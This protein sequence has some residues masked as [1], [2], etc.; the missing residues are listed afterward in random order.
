M[1]Q[2]Y[3]TPPPPPGAPPA[4]KKGLPV[5]AWVAIGCVGLLIVTGIVITAAGYW[6]VGK[7]KDQVGDFEKN[8][9]MAAAKLIVAANPELELISSDDEAQTL[10]VRNKKSG[11]EVTL[12]LADLR[13]GKI[14]FSQDGKESAIAFGTQGEDAGTMTVTGEGGETTFRAGAG[15]AV[16]LPSWVPVYPGSDP[17]GTYSTT[18]GGQTTGA[19]SL[20]TSDSVKEVLDFYAGELEPMG[21]KLERSTYSAGGN[22]GGILSG[23]TTDGTRKVN[24][25]VNRSGAE[26]GVNLTYTEKE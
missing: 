4:K 15:S 1:N 25:V 22:E 16:E 13:Q 21:A 24:L 12:S 26:T 11:E 2:P 8:P 10:T 9:E 17:A 14:S 19:Y 3:S 5:L 7:V 18:S 23:G 20:T 6:A